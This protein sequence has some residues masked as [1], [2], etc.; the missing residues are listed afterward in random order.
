LIQEIQFLS[1]A[2]CRSMSPLV[3]LKCAK[4][5]PAKT[6]DRPSLAQLSY[7][8]LGLQSSPRMAV[9]LEMLRAEQRDG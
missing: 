5:V 1:V 7:H 6:E 2:V 9:V 4:I 3:A 8:R